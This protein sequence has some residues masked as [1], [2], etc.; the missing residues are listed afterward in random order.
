MSPMDMMRTQSIMTLDD[1]DFT[2]RM[3]YVSCCDGDDA[4]RFNLGLLRYSFHKRHPDKS[5]R[6][7]ADFS[8]Q[9]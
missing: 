6:E 4:L 9:I 7:D 2:D 5:G 1:V 3:W 8:F